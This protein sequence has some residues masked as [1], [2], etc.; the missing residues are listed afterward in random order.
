[1]PDTTVPGTA[2][3]TTGVVTHC[4]GLHVPGGTFACC[5]RDHDCMPCCERCPTCPGQ[6][7]GWGAQFWEW[8]DAATAAAK[9]IQALGEKSTTHG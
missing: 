8:G 1:M 5:S 3:V 7:S 9:A 2:L 6:P 4:C